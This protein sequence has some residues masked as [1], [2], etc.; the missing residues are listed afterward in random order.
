MEIIGL[1]LIGIRTHWIYGPLETC[2]LIK[3]R[4]RSKEAAICASFIEITFKFKLN[5][6]LDRNP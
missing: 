4:A 5:P 3:L 2:R 1:M 6:K